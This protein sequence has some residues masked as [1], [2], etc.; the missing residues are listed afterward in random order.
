MVSPHTC[1]ISSLYDLVH[2]YIEDNVLLYPFFSPPPF[3]NGCNPYSSE[4]IHA[5]ELTTLTQCTI[6]V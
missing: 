5:Y 1:Y 3:R 4:H 2:T 6:T